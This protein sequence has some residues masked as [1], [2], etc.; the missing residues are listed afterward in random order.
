MIDIGSD[1]ESLGPSKPEGE[2]STSDQFLSNSLVNTSVGKLE[3][4]ID[5]LLL[6]YGGGNR[7]SILTAKILE[8]SSL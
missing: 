5:L 1:V 6:E 4:V 2:E 3:I 7:R 8:W